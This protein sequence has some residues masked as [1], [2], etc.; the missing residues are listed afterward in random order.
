MVIDS[1]NWDDAQD[2]LA[3]TGFL[4]QSIPYIVNLKIQNKP[5]VNFKEIDEGYYEK[6]VFQRI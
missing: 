2:I 3:D 4:N 1:N 5:E 6:V